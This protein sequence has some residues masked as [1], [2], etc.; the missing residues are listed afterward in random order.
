MG[1]PATAVNSLTASPY[2][3][4]RN[5]FRACRREV[6][7]QLALVTELH[8]LALDGGGTDLTNDFGITRARAVLRYRVPSCRQPHNAVSPCLWRRAHILLYCA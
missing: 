2:G 1:Q 8:F 7:G 5:M 4:D 6:Q 3:N